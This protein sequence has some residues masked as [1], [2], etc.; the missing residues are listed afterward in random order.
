M[1]II[2]KPVPNPSVE[3]I[4]REWNLRFELLEAVEISTIV[5]VP[6]Q[7]ARAVANRATPERVAEYMEGMKAG[8]P[9]PPLVLREPRIQLDGNTRREAALALDIQYFPAY[10]VHD[11]ASNSLALA[12]STQ[13]NQLNGDRLNDADAMHSA[14]ELLD[15]DLELPIS[16]VAGVVNRSPAQIRSWQANLVATQHAERLGISEQFH[17]VRRDDRRS[18]R[19]SS[20]TSR[21][22]AWSSCCRW[23]RTSPRRNSPS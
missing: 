10:V 6:E 23:S 11:I 20:W 17:A 9:F 21:S 5:Q 2:I 19:R 4:F 7:Q 3:A 8:G 22:A 1:S 13:I 16:K 15:G 14:L 18:W 12:L